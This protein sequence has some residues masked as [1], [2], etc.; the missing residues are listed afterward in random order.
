MTIVVASGKGGTGKTTV[1][2]GLAEIAADPVALLDCDVEGANAHL[3]L[4][5]ESG[6]HAASD[7]VRAERA[8][9][10]VLVPS[11]DESLCSGCGA[12]A[13]FC[14][15]GAL[16]VV[17]STPLFFADL[18]HACGG[19]RRVC[20]EGAITEVPHRIGEVVS[21][22]VPGHD[23]GSRWHAYG[24]LDVGQTLAPPLIREVQRH[25]HGAQTVVV[26]S[27]PGTTCPMVESVR[28][29]DVGLLVTE[30]TPFGLHDLD[31][32]ASVFADLGIPAGVLVNR[33]GIGYADEKLLLEL[34]G[35]HGLPVL[36]RIP[37]SET[38]AAGY[39]NGVSI[40]HSD[41]SLRTLFA[42]LLAD[43]ARLAEGDANE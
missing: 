26:D 15:F 34:C 13:E 32:A 27:P 31:L 42:D 35:R 20:P 33:Y 25:A 36:A 12:C 41:P 37:F 3:F 40:L 6:A 4:G 22:A 11:I 19:C 21:T 38:I 17:G 10:T 14:A 39:A 7:G 18:C 2:L 8:A 29:A 23:R 5:G 1:S 28:S 43:L 9:F 30:N 24:E 16:A